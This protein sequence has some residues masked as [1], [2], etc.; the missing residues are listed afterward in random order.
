MYRA[1]EGEEDKGRTGMRIS[2]SGLDCKHTNC[3]QQPL[4]VMDKGCLVGGL[5]FPFGCLEV[6]GL[7]D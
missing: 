4:T 1:K 2:E 6:I 3:S 7:I 5:R